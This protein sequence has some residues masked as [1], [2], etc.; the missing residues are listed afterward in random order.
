MRK[1]II[2]TVFAIL[3]VFVSVFATK[4]ISRS[5]KD[6]TYIQACED[7]KNGDFKA[8]HEALTGLD[9]YK[10][11]NELLKETKYKL[12]LE[13]FNEKDYDSSYDYFIELGDYKDSKNYVKE[14][15]YLRMLSAI[16]ENKLDEAYALASEIADY[17]DVSYQKQVIMY[18]RFM[19]ALNAYDVNAYKAYAGAL[20]DPGLQTKA[21]RVLEFTHHG[22]PIINE[23]R[24]DAEAEGAVVE[25][26]EVRCYQFSYNNN[27]EVPVYMFYTV[28]TDKDGVASDRYMVYLDNIYYGYCDTV[29]KT[30]LNMKDGQQLY[31]FTYLDR[32]DDDSTYKLSI[33]AMK[34]LSSK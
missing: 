7:I 6:N 21:E 28:Y 34:I 26:K 22:F 1:V 5:Q 4:I 13:T 29:D 3:L 30:K 15:T 33:E 19:N 11:S 14:I 17:K 20:N 24:N 23:I 10:D 9:G 2:I 32:W 25:F 27:V 16:D 12:G 8:A 18:E 31:A